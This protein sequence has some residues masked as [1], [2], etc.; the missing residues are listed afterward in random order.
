MWNSPVCVDASIVLRLVGSGT[1]ESPVVRLWTAWHEAGRPLVAP[2][3]LPYEVTSALR[4]YVAHGEL[5]PEEA[6]EALDVVLDLGIALHG[7][8]DLHRRALHLAEHF[9]LPAAYDAHY[10]ALAERLGAEFW[11]ADRRLIRALGDAVPGAR[12]LG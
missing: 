4:R 1:H 11:T 2:T 5:R 10:L 7:D 9:A 3:L 12:L 8:A 6:G